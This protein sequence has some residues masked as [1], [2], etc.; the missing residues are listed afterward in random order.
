MTEETQKTEQTEQIT[1]LTKYSVI[2]RF[3]SVPKEIDVTN[4]V[5]CEN[6]YTKQ[7]TYKFIDFEGR[8]WHDVPYTDIIHIQNFPNKEDIEEFARLERESIENT[9]QFINTKKDISD[10]SIG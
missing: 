7:L 5:L 9:K 4:I 1:Q 10:V 6:K 3:W 8:I 2:F